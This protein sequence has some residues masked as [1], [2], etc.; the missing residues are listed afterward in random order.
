M[1]NRYAIVLAAGKGTRMKSKKPKVLHAVG[2]KPMVSHVV[3]QVQAA[4]FEQTAVVIGHEGEQ[5]QQALG[6][7][8]DVVWQTER[9]G[10]GHAVKQ[11]EPLLGNKKGVT[12][13]I[14]A[15][16][17]MISAVTMQALSDHHEH[18]GAA[19]TV[20]TARV[21]DP[22]G[23]G[24]VIRDTRTGDVEKIV[25]HKDATA[26]E[27]GISEINTATYCIDNEALFSALEEVTN[28][29]AQQEYYLPDVI[30][31]L[32]TRGEKVSAWETPDASEALGVNDRVA[33]ADAEKV[34]QRRINE[35]WMKQGVTFVDPDYTYVSA[36]AELSPDT[37]LYP[38]TILRGQTVVG[39][40]CV[41]GPHSDISDSAIAGFTTI[42]QS[43]VCSSA[44][45]EHVHIGPFAHIRPETNIA[46]GA[47]VGNFVEIKKSNIG[48]DSKA[49]H[50]SYIGDADVGEDVNLGCGAITVNYDGKEKHLTTIEDGSFIG[51]NA[52]LIAPVTV[53]KNSFVAAGSTITENV[54][55]EALSIARSRQSNKEGY[56][57]DK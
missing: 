35:Y 32:K 49:N 18:S 46:N 21:E 33:L 56:M 8:V 47:K 13:V 17:P 42:N 4:G 50:L 36:D 44:I 26:K 45:G 20:L 39:E 54:P 37:T 24:R 57:K 30:E 1:D 40:G 6:N 52:N 9:L 55:G 48:K 43:T 10:T 38:G 7:E 3:E 27:R 28:D 53:G 2:G 15:D 19:V 41:I 11:A 16:T 34:M 12:L 31:I 51:C 5:V 23:L 29:N 22:T 14:S 25:E